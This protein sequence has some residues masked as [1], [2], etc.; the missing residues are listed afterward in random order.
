MTNPVL[1]RALETWGEQA[2]M[3][4]VV[5]EMSELMKEVLKNIN[6]KKN[7]IDAIIEETADVEIMLE[8]LKENYKI[9]EKV[10]AY[11]KDKIKLIEQ[12]L[13]DWDKK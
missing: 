9:I 2:Q 6:R 7:N 4:M 11:K 8:Q 13:N 5:E 10:E 3:L 1:K 12:R